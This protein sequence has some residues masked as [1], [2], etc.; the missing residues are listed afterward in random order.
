VDE[1]AVT[2]TNLHV[3]PPLQ[4]KN[5]GLSYLDDFKLQFQCVEEDDVV[6]I[7]QICIYPTIVC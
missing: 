7:S 5:F 2:L 1:F 6:G 3:H 4:V